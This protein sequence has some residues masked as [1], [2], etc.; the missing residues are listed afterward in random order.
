[1]S[2]KWPLKKIS[3][4][5]DFLNSKRIPLKSLDRQKRQGP[6]PYYGAS[7]IVDR[8][9]G[10]IFDGTYLLISEDGENLRTRKTPIAFKAHGKFWV[11]NHAHILS[12]KE[13]GVLDYLEYYFSTLDL[14]PYITGA[15][16]PK[17]NKANLDSIEIPF[18]D[19]DTRLFIN[20]T[21][22]SLTQKVAINH[23]LNQTLEQMAQA[24]FKSWF[25]NFEPVKAKIAVLE[26]GGSQEE[27]MLA[28]MTAIS[29]K[30]VDAL[31]FFEHEHP[32]QY[33][34]LKA[35]AELFSSA[36]QEGELGETPEG[37]TLSEIGKEIDI[38]GGAT[39]ST[40]TP[41]F[42]ENGD[43]NWTTPKDLSDLKDKIL[44]HTERKITKTGLRKISSGLL[45]V[46]TV[47][48]SSRAPVGYLAMA[49]IPVAI[50]QGYIAMKCNKDLSPEFV[51][52]WCVANM[53]EIVSRASGTTF[54]EISKKNFNPIPLVKPP[55]KLVKSYTKQLSAIYTLIEN[56]ARENNN[57]T[58]L[59]DTLLPKLLSGQI[60][61][62]EAEQAISEVE[63]V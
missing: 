8:I 4:I 46:N 7:G 37:W 62:P 40:K 51:L 1:M 13:E 34:E 31:A 27:A 61:L 35:T 57:L 6:Y 33:A 28:A 43:I 16:Q 47:L 49:K 60:T 14:D 20:A 63:N 55:V 32:E 9:D 17:L 24:L 11:N 2:S 54:A 45:P 44:L 48:M 52:Q 30:D 18:P 3:E 25:V 22:N 56:N 59:R 23:K 39:P 5:A 21:L 10:Y 38:T 58:Q 42:W 19:K 41:E 12:E 15:V 36:M 26:S 29:G 50:N 53:P